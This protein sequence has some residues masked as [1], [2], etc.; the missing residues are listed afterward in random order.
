MVLIATI[1]FNLNSVKNEIRDQ[2]A[3]PFFLYLPPLLTRFSEGAMEVISK[4]VAT[5]AWFEILLREVGVSFKRL[6]K[7]QVFADRNTML[8]V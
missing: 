3:G 6:R 5:S 4:G 7:N 2:Q 8:A 1:K